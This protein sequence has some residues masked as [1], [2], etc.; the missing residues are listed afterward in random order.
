MPLSGTTRALNK[1]YFIGK[2]FVYFFPLIY[3]NKGETINNRREAVT[4]D[5]SL[6][7][8]RTISSS[9]AP[10]GRNPLQMCVAPNFKSDV[11]AL[12]ITPS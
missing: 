6:H 9:G 10:E 11:P 7:L 5:A 12:L 1:P 3:N 4:T 2:I 8:R